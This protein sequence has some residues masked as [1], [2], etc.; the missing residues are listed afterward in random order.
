MIVLT[1]CSHAVLLLWILF[2]DYLTSLSLLCCLIC[3]LQFFDHLLGKG[4]PLGEY[5]IVKI[6][7]TNIC[8]KAILYALFTFLEVVME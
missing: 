3:F 4:L 1:R 7:Q 2:G 5:R 6:K 8:R